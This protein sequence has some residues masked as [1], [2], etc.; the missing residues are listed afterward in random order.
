MSKKV[1]KRP[2]KAKKRVATDTNKVKQML[3]QLMKSAE[4]KFYYVKRVKE[5]D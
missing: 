4:K 2:N 3:I 5:S 1:L